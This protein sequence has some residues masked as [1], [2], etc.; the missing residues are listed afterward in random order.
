MVKRSKINLGFLLACV[1]ILLVGILSFHSLKRYGHET[2]VNFQR[3]SVLTDVEKI[4]A[5]YE[6]AKSNVRGFHVSGNE[7]M[8]EQYH[9]TK[10]RLNALVDHL[11]KEFPEKDSR[12]LSLRELKYQLK[13]RT[14]HWEFHISERRKNG[15][16]YTQILSKETSW[17]S[18]EEKIYSSIRTI[19]YEEARRAK[20][21]VSNLEVFN[22]LTATA[23]IIGSLLAIGLVLGAAIKVNLDTIKREIAE[24]DIE[25]FFEVSLD[26]LS[27]SGMDGKFIKF[28][29]AWCEL[30]GYGREELMNVSL[31]ELVHPEDL[32]KTLDEIEKQ[33]NGGKVLHF[34]NRWRCKNGNYVDL[35]WKSV[36]VGQTMYG[37]A[38]DIT[39]QKLFEK[40]LIDA[41]KNSLEAAKVKSEFLANMSHEIRTPINGILG[42][43][44]LLGQTELSN[45]QTGLLATLK[46][47]GSL[48]LKI[49]N[50]ILDFS[51]IEAGKLELEMIDF[52]VVSLVETQI[53]MVGPMAAD[54]K[55]TVMATVDPQIPA[56]VKGDSGRISQILLNLLNNGIKFTDKGHVKLNV[57]LVSKTED[58]AVL[59]FTVED[60]GIG[61]TDSQIRR[62]FSPF[63]QADSSTARKYGGTGLGLSISKR[64]AEMMNGQIGVISVPDKGSTF[65]FTAKVSYSEIQK[66][67]EKLSFHPQVRSLQ[68][69]VAEDNL[70]NQ[71]LIKKMLEKL[72]H[73]VFMA[74]NGLEAVNMFKDMNYDLILMDHH[75]PVMDGMEAVKL[76]RKMETP[77]THTP[78]LAFTANVLQEA[79]LSFS[80][81]GVDDFV[82]KPVTLATLE[83]S[84]G[85]WMNV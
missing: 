58:A 78:I 47:S 33:K 6:L 51:K 12:R 64:L 3:L 53:S 57:G 59:K 67:A 75:M 52:N 16:G 46:N 63:E 73:T 40:E 1:L 77:G 82:L 60:S 20:D 38:R 37:A 22:R 23:I 21:V 61:M 74:G 54:K 68:V 70:V 15:I 43:T 26:L 39:K 29:P 65:W 62:I 81:A 48:L 24:R 32:P 35:S 31:L 11:T 66:T 80:E 41:Q 69:L 36:P 44:E 14:D 13:L 34:E 8:V 56:Y 19:K 5:E 25:T 2:E 49:I 18:I 27:I 84:L 30:L 71:M 9:L 50:E 42:V 28:S 79:Q 83:A 85:K 72:G 76:I 7:N 45:E 10:S 17:R 55:L 4:L